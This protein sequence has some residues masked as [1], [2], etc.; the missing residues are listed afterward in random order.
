MSDQQVT[1]QGPQSKAKHPGGRPRKPKPAPPLPPPARY[2]LEETLL[3][4]DAAALKAGVSPASQLRWYSD[5]VQIVKDIQAKADAARHDTLEIGNK[6]LR[7]SIEAFQRTQQNLENELRE[8]D[9]D[10]VEVRAEND[11]ISAKLKQMSDERAKQVGEL[12]NNVR[13]TQ[14]KAEGLLA[15]VR[16][17]CL[18]MEQHSEGQRIQYAAQLMSFSEQALKN[19][20]QLERLVNNPEAHRKAYADTCWK[21]ASSRI[22]QQLTSEQFAQAK[23]IQEEMIERSMQAYREKLAFEFSN[24]VPEEVMNLAFEVL[25][26]TREQVV[27]QLDKERQEGK[28]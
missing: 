25:S 3:M 12:T 17:V 21:A 10:L 7:E 14:K 2:S 26:V 22:G 20:H 27:K 24:V 4:G 15:L 11:K 8:R 1:E 5:R 19:A 9:R 28:A 6:R 23:R 18:Q 13:T 16:C